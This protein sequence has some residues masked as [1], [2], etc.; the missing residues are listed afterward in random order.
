MAFGSK[1]R[2]QRISDLRMIRGH[3]F[4]DIQGHETI[5]T[6][7]QHAKITEF[8]LELRLPQPPLQVFPQRVC[9]QNLLG[10]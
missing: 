8:S 5:L 2:W 9:F 3:E 1:Q 6:R 7:L 4:F 10:R